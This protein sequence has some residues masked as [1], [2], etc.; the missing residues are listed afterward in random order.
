MRDMFGIDG[1]CLA[2]A[3]RPTLWGNAPSELNNHKALKE[4]LPPG[5]VERPTLTQ[6]QIIQ[7]KPL[8]SQ[9]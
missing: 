7:I 8:I 3:F 2:L 9:P 5:L 6:N 4:R 1:A